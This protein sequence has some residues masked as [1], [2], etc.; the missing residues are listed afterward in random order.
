[1]EIC[2][3]IVAR[4]GSKR[5]PRKSLLKLNGESLIARKIRQL[6]SCKKINRIVFGSDSE[7]MLLEAKSHGAEIVRRPKFYCDEE[8]ASA[9]DMIKNMCE[10]IRTEVVVWAHCTNPLLSPSTYDDAVCT[11]FDN[12]KAFDSLLS[13]V[14][15]REHIWTPDKKPLNYNPYAPRHT[16]ARELP[17]YYFQDGGIFIQPYEQMRKNHY[18]FGRAPY[19]YV[20]PQ[21]EFADINTMRDYLWTKFLLEHA[22]INDNQDYDKLNALGGGINRSLSFR[23]FFSLELMSP[24]EESEAAA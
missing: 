23:L 2:A 7:E 15:F 4:G 13:V 20:I 8:L 11:F 5:I 22:M 10:F 3:V 9:N 6:H 24:R 21:D 12:R 16:P 19:L 1:M 14:S 18:F 17:T